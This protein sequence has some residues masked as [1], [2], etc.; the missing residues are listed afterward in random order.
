MKKY[1]LYKHKSRFKARDLLKFQ[2][3]IK[4]LRK[5]AFAAPE[6]FDF[7]NTKLFVHQQIFFIVIFLKKHLFKVSLLLKV[8]VGGGDTKNSPCIYIQSVF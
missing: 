8:K 2:R 3:L 1:F 6:M 4:F 7:V 5:N